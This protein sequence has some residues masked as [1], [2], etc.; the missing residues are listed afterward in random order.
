[1]TES[2][3]HVI[4]WH[5]YKNL[6]INDMNPVSV[7][8]FYLSNKHLGAHD[9]LIEYNKQLAESW[10]EDL[11]HLPPGVCY[12]AIGRMYELKQ[13]LKS[14][15]YWYFMRC[16]IDLSGITYRDSNYS[17][18]R[19]RVSVAPA[20]LADTKN[21]IDTLMLSDKEL[22][23]LYMEAASSLKIPGAAYSVKEAYPLIIEA[24]K[25]I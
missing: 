5:Q 9:V 13:D 23:K 14:A 17:D 15:L 19:E 7:H 8:S 25:N 4:L 24:V 6:M 2:Y 11:D 16:Y 12:Y 18:I 20:L 1:M 22:Q 3:S 21:C 10:L